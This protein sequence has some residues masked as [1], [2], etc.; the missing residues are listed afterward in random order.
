MRDVMDVY[1]VYN[2][3]VGILSLDREKAF[4]RID[5]NFLFSV[6]K[7]FGFGEKFIA[8]VTLLY[9]NASCMV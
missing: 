8:W 4:D 7:A 6:F 1:N 3:S 2:Q 5:H 9:N